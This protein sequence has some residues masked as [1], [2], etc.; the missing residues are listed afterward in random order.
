M[1]D[2]L[3]WV[4]HSY[5]PRT[6]CPFCPNNSVFLSNQKET[7]DHFYSVHS[8]SV[9]LFQKQLFLAKKKFFCWNCPSKDSG[10]VYYDEH[11][12]LVSHIE[13]NHQKLKCEQCSVWYKSLDSLRHHYIS[14]HHII[15]TC[16]LNDMCTI[17][18]QKAMNMLERKNLNRDGPSF[19]T[20][21][22]K[23]KCQI[24]FLPSTPPKLESKQT[25]PPFLSFHDQ[26]FF[27][28]EIVNYP[29]FIST[30]TTDVFLPVDTPQ[31]P[32]LD[33][34]DFFGVAALIM[35]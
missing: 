10:S 13:R 17:S 31:K 33:R 34:N 4:I 12:E 22:S 28:H 2:L 11:D 35:E 23:S 26:L 14:M 32:I 29:P 27:K 6:Y 9:P 7:C 8:D 25:S 16:L 30:K 5:K 15:D 20:F 21:P 3:N 19:V 18:Q 1:E 24:P